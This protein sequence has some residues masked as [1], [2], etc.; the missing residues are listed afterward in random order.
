MRDRLIV[1]KLCGPK[2][3][4]LMHGV[5]HLNAVLELELL[6][7]GYGIAAFWGMQF[8]FKF[9]N[10]EGLFRERLSVDVKARDGP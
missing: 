5:A 4:V 9:A 2:E 1:F 3:G 6:R 7:R 10:G 8:R